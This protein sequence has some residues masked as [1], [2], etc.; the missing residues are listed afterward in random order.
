MVYQRMPGLSQELT[1][2]K[3]EMTQPSRYEK[4]ANQRA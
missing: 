3:L 1:G 2:L 4:E